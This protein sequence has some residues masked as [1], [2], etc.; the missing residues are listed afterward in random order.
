LSA[1]GGAA[2][3]GPGK[4]IRNP[5]P[6]FPMPEQMS[7]NYLAILTA[8]VSTFMLGGLW[9]SPRLFGRAW[10][11]EMG[12]TDESL[13][14][15]G[16]V[17]RIMGISFVLELIMAFNLAAFIGPKASLGFGL[18]AGAAAGFGWVALSL[19][20]TYLFERKPLRLFLI[21]AGYHGVAFTVMGAI[22]GAWR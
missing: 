2:N 21:N 5:K 11:Q 19:G 1:W 22:L 20:V 7:F 4:S 13:K 6:G 17:G 18:F 12:F 9:Y 8:T 14:A 15:K 10:M 3:T 16:D